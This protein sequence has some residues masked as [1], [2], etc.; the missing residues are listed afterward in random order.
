M[1]SLWGRNRFSIVKHYWCFFFFILVTVEGKVYACGEATNG[2]LGLGISSGTVPIPRQIT[3][4]SNYVVKKVAVHSGTDNCYTFMHKHNILSLQ[5]VVLQFSWMLWN[6]SISDI[7]M[8]HKSKP[9]RLLNSACCTKHRIKSDSSIT[10]IYELRLYTVSYWRLNLVTS[11]FQENASIYEYC[12]VVG[13]V[14][15]FCCVFLFF[16]W[17][18]FLML[19]EKNTQQ[20]Q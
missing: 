15:F 11:E 8:K 6:L 2:R 18:L 4:L 10:K 5:I 1:Q 17:L 20:F 16:V 14:A 7:L 9:F 3:A 19:H 12:W 13:F